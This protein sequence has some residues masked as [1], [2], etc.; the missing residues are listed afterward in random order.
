MFA[1]LYFPSGYALLNVQYSVQLIL[2]SAWET[3]R[4]ER[5]VHTRYS[6]GKFN[7]LDV[8]KLLP[9]IRAILRERKQEQKISNQLNFRSIFITS[10]EDKALLLLLCWKF[11]AHSENLM[12]G[13]NSC[14]K[15]TFSI[16]YFDYGPVV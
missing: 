8:I 13:M 5:P 15:A 7:V 12:T 3:D 14:T 1:C 2:R 4:A 6:L 11:P 9:V 16:I 10:H